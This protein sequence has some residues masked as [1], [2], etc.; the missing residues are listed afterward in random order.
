MLTVR[1]N[2]VRSLTPHD[3]ASGVV[4]LVWVDP[5]AGSLT[6]PPHPRTLRPG[7]SFLSHRYKLF[8]IFLDFAEVVVLTRVA[9]SLCFESPKGCWNVAGIQRGPLAP[10]SPQP[11]WPGPPRSCILSGVLILDPQDGDVDSTVW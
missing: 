9:H 4:Q 2:G 11:S 3:H 10:P 5:G 1:G 7:I 8:S 6:P